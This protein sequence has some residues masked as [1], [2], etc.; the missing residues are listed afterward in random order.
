LRKILQ[1]GSEMLKPVADSKGISV[2]IEEDRPLWVYADPSSLQEILIN[3]MDNAIKYSP[4]SSSVRI[5]A[6]L[7]DYNQA[8][9]DEEISGQLVRL[10]VIDSGPGIPKTKQQQIFDQF[11]HGG[12]DQTLSREGLGLGLYI[13]KNLV[14]L[15]NGEI[16]V[17]SEEG[18]G[19]RFIFTLEGGLIHDKSESVE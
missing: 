19:S 3:L 4:E 17:E 16:R 12:I 10:A 15:H 7:M 8:G 18:K 9:T 6:T 14:D 1:E 11:E 5:K 2:I 13:V